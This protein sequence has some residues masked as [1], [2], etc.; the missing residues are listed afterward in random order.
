VIWNSNYQKENS[1][2]SGLEF[3]AGKSPV[4]PLLGSNR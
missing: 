3:I 1:F 4:L 2:Q